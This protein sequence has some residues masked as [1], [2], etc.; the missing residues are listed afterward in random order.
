MIVKRI[1]FEHGTVYLGKKKELFTTLSGLLQSPNYFTTMSCVSI[2]PLEK[3]TDNGITVDDGLRS[4][5]GI[6]IKC[7]Y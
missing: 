7:F 5:T 4:K 2:V 6:F 1:N 3:E